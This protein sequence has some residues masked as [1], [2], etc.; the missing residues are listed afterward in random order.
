MKVF[1]SIDETDKHFNCS[2]ISIGMFDGVHCGHKKIVTNVLKR[3]KKTGCLSCLVTFDPHPRK[4]LKNPNMPLLIT[5]LE[6]KLR[7]IEQTGIDSVIIIGFDESFSSQNS[8][9]FIRRLWKSIKFSEVIVGDDFRFGKNRES[10]ITD[11]IKFGK[12]IGFTVTAI[13]PIA[14][15]GTIISSTEVRKRIQSGDLASAKEFLGR[16]VSILGTVVRGSNLGKKIGY[17]TA[18]IDPHQEILPPPG[19]YIVSVVLSGVFHKGLVNIG[20]SPTFTE[21]EKG[22]S[23]EVFI[24]DFEK[25]IYGEDVEIFFKR[26]IRNERKFDTLEELAKQIGEDVKVA[27]RYFGKLAMKN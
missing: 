20:F 6:H 1:R 10:G 27:E 24:F 13:K 8:E 4:Y 23:I 14:N 19:V 9:T 2:V 11:L 12:K 26:K 5:S 3:T 22:F 18:N 15:K 25:Q 7:L 16:E 21:R 17:P